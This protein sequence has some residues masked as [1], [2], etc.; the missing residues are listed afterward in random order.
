MSLSLEVANRIRAAIPGL[1]L[2]WLY[3]GDDRHSRARGFIDLPVILDGGLGTISLG[4]PEA[5]DWFIPQRASEMTGR[6]PPRPLNV[7]DVLSAIRSA[8][9][10][11]GA[12][13]A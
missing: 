9:A 3:H 4:G 6:A 5:V 8:Q 11:S 12:K 7:E 10:R 2:D 13:A 1:T